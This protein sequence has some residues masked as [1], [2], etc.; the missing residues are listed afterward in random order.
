VVRWRPSDRRTVISAAVIFSTVVVIILL[1]IGPLGSQVATVLALY[2]AILTAAVAVW[3]RSDTQENAERKPDNQQDPREWKRWIIGSAVGLLI[4]LICTS[5]DVPSAYSTLAVTGNV[6]L[7]RQDKKQFNST[8][9]L[10]F[11]LHDGQFGYFTRPDSRWWLPWSNIYVAPASWPGTGN[12]TVFA[13]D[14]SGLEFLGTEF[15][16]LIFGYRDNQL[17]WHAPAPAEINGYPVVGMQGRPGFLQY[18]VATATGETPYFLAFIP[19]TQG[20]VGV[21]M[22]TEQYPWYWNGPKIVLGPNADAI[23][24][25]AASELPDGSL[26]V[27]VRAGNHLYETMH[28]G[29]GL[30]WDLSA[31]W[32][33]LTEIRTPSGADINATGDPQLVTVSLPP[34][35]LTELYSAVPVRNGAIL[36]SQ[37]EGATTW[38]ADKLPIDGAINSI[39]LLA[40]SVSNRSNLDIIYRQGD[41][42]LTLWKWY[43]GPW[44]HLSLVKW[45]TGQKGH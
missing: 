13:S 27:I 33:K 38:S 41:S 43:N 15:S 18:P 42:L 24:S 44:H 8:P 5:A 14:Y 11:Q 28:S 40:G 10:V 19:R 4:L 25:V 37:V 21:Y 45:S 3:R 22:R 36:L 17:R 6:T 12:S 2:V 9:A 29:K 31:D 16:A 30:P 26:F 20:G 1:F 35:G 32:T 34:Y 23:T 7:V 39:T